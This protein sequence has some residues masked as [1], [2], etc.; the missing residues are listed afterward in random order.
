VVGSTGE[1]V[2]RYQGRIR[3]L[4]GTGVGGGRS[5]IDSSRIHSNIK[6]RSYVPER[7]LSYGQASGNA[8]CSS[9]GQE[10][11]R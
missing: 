8:E 3:E 9:T 5:V 11:P 4:L 6:R 7:L 10:M 2:R 1:A